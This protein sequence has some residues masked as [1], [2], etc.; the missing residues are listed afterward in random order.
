MR[1]LFLTLLLSSAFAAMVLASKD[2]SAAAPTTAPSSLAA[3]KPVNEFCPIQ[4]GNEID[5]KITV[6]HDGKVIGFCCTEC[7]GEF[8]HD[9]AKHMEAVK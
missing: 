9:P 5:A 6:V 3:G 7:A 8:K 4:K 2:H 1:F